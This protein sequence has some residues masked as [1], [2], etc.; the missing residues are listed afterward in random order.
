MDKKENC[1]YEGVEFFEDIIF[2]LSSKIVKGCIDVA[3]TFGTVH[4]LTWDD[5]IKYN[6]KED[7]N[8]HII[9]NED[10]ILSQMK[11]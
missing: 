1:L 7:A 4:G 6:N 11:K 3:S 5:K 9:I 2:T 10:K 8:E